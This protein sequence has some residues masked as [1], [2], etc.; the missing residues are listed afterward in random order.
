MFGVANG[1]GGVG[2]P[3]TVMRPDTATNVSGR[4]IDFSF[5]TVGSSPNTFRIQISSGGGALTVSRSSGTGSFAVT[6]HKIAGG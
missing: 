6:V 5:T 1:G 4:P 2:F 3:F